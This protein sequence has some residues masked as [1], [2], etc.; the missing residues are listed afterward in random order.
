MRATILAAVLLRALVYALLGLAIETL[1]TACYEAYVGSRPDSEN[2][3]VR[4]P[5]SRAERLRLAGRS[6]LWMMPIYGVGLLALEPVRDRVRAWHWGARGVLWMT[7]IFAVEYLAGVVIK[8]LTGR[9][10]WD[11]SSLRWSVHGYIRLD[12][13]PLWMLVGLFIER[14]VDFVRAAEPALRAAF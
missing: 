4:N 10:P 3:R 12:Y 14:V 2:P 1:W 11:Y 5:L 9:C 8:T 13:A 7:A 6:Y